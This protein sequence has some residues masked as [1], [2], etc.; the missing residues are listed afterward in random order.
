MSDYIE[1][2]QF[3]LIAEQMRV[4]HKY[5]RKATVLSGQPVDEL[6]KVLEDLNDMPILGSRR[7]SY[8]ASFKL[9][10]SQYKI[11]CKSLSAVVSE[12][13]QLKMQKRRNDEPF[14]LV[15]PYILANGAYYRVD[16]VTMKI[17]TEPMIWP[18][19]VTLKMFEKDIHKCPLTGRFNVSKTLKS[20]LASAQKIG[21][22]RDHVGYVLQRL[23]KEEMPEHYGAVQYLEDSLQIWNQC[24]A[25]IDYNDDKMEV[26]SAMKRIVRQPGE[27]IVMPAMTFHSLMCELISMETGQEI[28]DDDVIEKA[29]YETGRALKN[30]VQSDT[31][32]LLHTTLV[33]KYA[34][35]KTKCSF[36]DKLKIITEIEQTHKLQLE[37][38][39]NMN[40]VDISVYNVAVNHN[41]QTYRNVPGSHPER[42][43]DYDDD[44]YTAGAHASDYPMAASSRYRSRHQPQQSSQTHSTS[45]CRLCGLNQDKDH[46]NPSICP[47]Y[48]QI[49]TS[50]KKC[51]ICWNKLK[52]AAFHFHSVCLNA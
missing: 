2:E 19:E 27:S 3:K 30:L 12:F 10:W 18:E 5:L 44:D 52:I 14:T 16:P 45:Q 46:T 24:V 20:I 1:R 32:T 40:K 11:G 35:F 48:G 38:P 51:Q 9:L 28:S 39:R 15:D 41:S 4:L 23:I 49:K 22:T 29:D 37:F 17:D 8:E 7:E 43:R 50:D 13:E 6:D 42:S 26:I 25:L 33:Q 36:K 21:C 47:Y 31:W 34:M